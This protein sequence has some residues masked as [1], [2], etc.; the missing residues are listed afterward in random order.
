M[1]IDSPTAMEE[2]GDEYGISVLVGSGPFKFKEWV[3]NDHVT[4]VRNDDYNWPSPIFEHTGPAYLDELIYR[5]M[6]EYET[7]ASAMEIGEIHVARLT[8]SVLSRFEGNPDFAIMPV[9]KAGTA[10]NFLLNM[11]VEPTNDIRVRQA[12]AHAVDEEGLLMLPFLS[13]YGA[14][15]L[16]PLPSNIMPASTDLS[17]FKENAYEYD[18]E[19]AMALLEEAGW[20]DEDGDGIREKDG[21]K[22]VFLIPTYT[23]PEIEAVSGMLRDVG[24]DTDIKSGDFNFAYSEW[25]KREFQMI[26]SSDSGYDPVRL[27]T[28]FFY[29]ESPSDFTGYSNADAELAAASNALSLDEMW[30][31]LIK[32]QAKIL[33]DAVA[34]PGYE[35]H[36]PYV[37]NEKVQHLFFNEV[38]FPYFYGTWIDE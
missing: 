19:K 16:S 37:A 29:S 2:A 11:Q 28:Y 24:I 15:G 26:I 10:R 23:L 20:V 12:V 31:N 25:E 33:K 6:T 4:L 32:A 18:P 8:E 35:R 36:Y 1:G 30:D 3:R 38:A 27:L 9:P 17:I 14:P 5:D 34:V 21:E 13:G 22:L 7:M